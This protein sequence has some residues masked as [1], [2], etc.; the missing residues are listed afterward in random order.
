MSSSLQA[1]RPIDDD[2]VIEAR[3]ISVYFDMDRGVSRVVD[4]VDMEL[5]RDEA[6]GVVGESG[7][8]KSMFATALINSVIEPGQVSGEV[9]YNPSDGE[10]IDIL[11]LSDEELK[12]YRWREISM[13]F[14]GAQDSFNPTMRIKGH[15]E[16]TLISHNASM[17]QGMERARDLLSDLYLDPDRVLESFPHELSGGMKQR[18]LIALSLLL[19]P[20]VLLLD[21]PTSSLDLLMQRAIMSLLD[22]IQDTYDFTYLFIT[23]DLPQIAGLVD[24]VAVMY[25]FEFV[26]AGPAHEVLQD[27]QHPYTRALLNAAPSFDTPVDEMAP[28]EGKSPDPINVPSGCSYHER[29]P[30]ADEQ[31]EQQDP[32]LDQVMENRRVACFHWE[33]SADAIPY[34]LGKGVDA[35]ETSNRDVDVS[36]TASQEAEDPVVSMDDIEVHFE[37]AGVI[38][39]FREG[40]KP[41]KAVDGVSLD[42]PENDVVALVGESGCGKTTLGKTAVALQRPTGGSLEFRGQDV[43]D[44]KDAIT[45]D[46]DDRS[47]AE[48]RKSLQIIHQDPGSSLN[49]GRTVQS[50]LRDPLKKEYPNLGPEERESIIR[51][52]LEYVG[53]VPSDDYAVRYPH[54]LSGGEKQRVALA[55]AVLMNPDLILADEAVSARDVA[56]RVEMMDLLID[57]QE[58]FET[59]FLFITHDFGNARY[60]T[61]KADGR[62]GVMY[63][64]N[65][66]EIGHVEEVL[67]N[68]KHPYTQILIWATPV[69]DPDIAAEKIDQEPPIRSIDIPDPVDTPTGCNFHPRCPEAREACT[70]EEPE[71]IEAADGTTAACFRQDDDHEYWDSEPLYEDEA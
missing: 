5:Y 4:N 63:L 57:L 30:L 55:R 8:G 64:G 1:Q 38:E 47:F 25:A 45:V 69:L 71:I 27:A 7:S 43:W 16:E 14:Q 36:E 58:M 61:T 68:P 67:K 31:C 62:I 20:D 17:D 29:C 32:E 50:S 18:T 60:I 52:I 66:V 37:T 26:E 28:I 6:L 34:T 51:G 2:V 22:R 49:P 56:L 46:D 35:M 11:E 15:F 40:P 65:L 33:D 19:D 12:K 41:A 42:I 70:R 9:I 21:E 48:I 53:M 10:P 54:Q 39:R 24:R 23:H 13:V 44:T 3:D 59:S